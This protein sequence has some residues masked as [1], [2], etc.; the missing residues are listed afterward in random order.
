MSV[1]LDFPEFP[2]E[3]PPG[4]IT[5]R[6]EPWNGVLVAV[7][8]IPFKTGDKVTFHITVCSD[9]TGQTPAAEIQGVASITADTTSASYTIPWDGVLDAVT[10]GSIIA[11]YTLTP[12]DGSASSTSQEAI[13]RYS[14]QRPGGAV[15]G[16]DD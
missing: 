3:E 5:C 10:E 4:G 11:F 9:A 8:Q 13:V 16:P 1:E 14:R 2:Y 7:D 15:C 12:A 6:Q